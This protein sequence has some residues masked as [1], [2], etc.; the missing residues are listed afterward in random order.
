MEGPVGCCT[1]SK[2]A[3]DGKSGFRME[4]GKTSKQRQIPKAKDKSF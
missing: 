4:N 3:G 1:V 2:A